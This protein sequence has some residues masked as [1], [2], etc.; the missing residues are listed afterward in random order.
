MIKTIISDDT[1]EQE[2]KLSTATTQI[3][4]G[5]P[6]E[7]LYKENEDEGEENDLLKNINVDELLELVADLV[8]SMKYSKSY[9]ARESFKEKYLTI[10]R[11]ILTLIGF[12]KA[13]R[14]LPAVQMKPEVT[15]AI[16][17]GALAATAFFI[18]S[19]V[20]VKTEQPKPQANNLLQQ[21]KLEEERKKQQEE[22]FAKQVEQKIEKEQALSEEEI[23][24]FIE[25]AEEAKE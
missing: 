9:E 7:Q 10:N 6:P 24:K 15:I 21:M 12:D 1:V 8:A 11:L 18:K 25:A 16:G 20:P 13:L 5:E 22:A 23:Q 17:L 3:I 2:E 14:K 4:Q 19:D